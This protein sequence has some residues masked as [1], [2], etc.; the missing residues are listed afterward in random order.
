M[1]RPPEPT[2]ARDAGW[3]AHRA[4]LAHLEA[5]SEAMYA[6][7]ETGDLGEAESPAVAPYCGCGDCDVRET[8]AVAWP[9]LLADAA[10]I[11]DQAGH[12]GAAEI[13]R[14]ETA[15]VQQLL[16]PGL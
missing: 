10:A 1:T 6:A 14:A 8:L 9:I 2:S 7:E 3:E 16:A 5:C 13:L 15:R 12:A 11:V 4:A